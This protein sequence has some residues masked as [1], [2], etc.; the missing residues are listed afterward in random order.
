MDTSDRQVTERVPQYDR[1]DV[2]AVLA[3]GISTGQRRHFGMT[4]LFVE[5]A[6]KIAFAKNGNYRFALSVVRA[7]TAIS[8]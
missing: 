7:N 5:N 4:F 2:R 1:E 8:R 3:A 6:T